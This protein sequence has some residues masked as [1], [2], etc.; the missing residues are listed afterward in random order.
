[1]Q[2]A[3][4]KAVLVSFDFRQRDCDL[5]GRFAQ[6]LSTNMDWLVKNGHP[7]WKAVDL[8]FPLKGWDAVRLRRE[9]RAAAR[10]ARRGVDA[11][12]APPNPVLDA[13]KTMLGN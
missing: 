12:S 4:V 3:A 7:K 13:M 1:M 9:V 10:P 5:I 6:A 11:P 2:T 8:D